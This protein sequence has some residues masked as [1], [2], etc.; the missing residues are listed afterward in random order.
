VKKDRGEGFASLD[1]GFH[2]SI[3]WQLLEDFLMLPREGSLGRQAWRVE[4]Q[5]TVSFKEATS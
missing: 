1:K 3:V 4:G 2:P 5:L